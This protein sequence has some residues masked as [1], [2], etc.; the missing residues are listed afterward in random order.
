MMLRMLFLVPFYPWTTDIP[1][2]CKNCNHVDMETMRCK[3]FGNV[4][5]V[6]GERMYWTTNM[7]RQNSSLCGEQGRFFTRYIPFST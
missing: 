3:L 7:V 6:T 2:I 5:V 4:D 1:P